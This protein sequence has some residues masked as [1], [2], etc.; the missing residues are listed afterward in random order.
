M[1]LFTQYTTARGLSLSAV[2]VSLHFL[3]RCLCSTVTCR[4]P[5]QWIQINPDSKPK[6][7]IRAIKTHKA[8]VT[9]K[10]T[11]VPVWIET[12]IEY[13]LYCSFYSFSFKIS[14]PN[15]LLQHE[16]CHLDNLFLVQDVF[17]NAGNIFRWC[18]ISH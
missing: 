12:I 3:S 14:F 11:S 18:D 9:N 16:N 2:S 7:H 6:K 10:N 13:R 8:C 4:A 15:F 17:H 1:L 5:I